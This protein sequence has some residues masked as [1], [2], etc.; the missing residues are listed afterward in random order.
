MMPV[1]EY[2]GGKIRIIRPMCEVPESMTRRVAERLDLPIFSNG[3]PHRD[4]NIRSHMKGVIRELSKLDRNV[5]EK[6]NRAHGNIQID[7]LPSRLQEK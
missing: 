1:Q 7:Y 6:I 5:R 2:F 3:C 4:T